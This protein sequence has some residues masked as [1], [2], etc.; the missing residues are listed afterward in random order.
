MFSILWRLR[1]SAPSRGKLIFLFY[2]NGML[3]YAPSNP[4]AK[5]E[6]EVADYPAIIHTWHPMRQRKELQYLSS[7]NGIKSVK[8]DS[9]T[10]TGQF[11]IN[12][13]GLAS[14]A[15]PA[16]EQDAQGLFANRLAS[17]NHA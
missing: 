4:I 14:L 13:E 7:Q 17:L 11:N 1:Q 12:T 6:D 2:F 5:H 15:F 3:E 9:K 10:P 16:V 8:E